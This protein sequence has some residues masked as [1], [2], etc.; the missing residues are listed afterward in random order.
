MGRTHV[1]LY[2]TRQWRGVGFCMPLA[3]SN[4]RKLAKS[5]AW[6]ETGYQLV[7]C[8]SRT[9]LESCFQPFYLDG[10]MCMRLRMIDTKKCLVVSILFMRVSYEL[11]CV[12][13]WM[14]FLSTPTNEL[15]ENK[16]LNGRQ[17]FQKSQGKEE[18]RRR[19]ETD[20]T[21]GTSGSINLLS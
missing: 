10:S 6:Q 7:L 12:W 3:S 1:S 16:T 19:G 14:Y 8:R 11:L 17:I 4:V 15:R 21:T 18:R 5:N 13:W 20:G 9:N 2:H